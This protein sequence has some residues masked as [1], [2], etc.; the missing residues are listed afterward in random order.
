MKK[1]FL[2]ASFLLL[3]SFVF[4]QNAGADKT[5]KLIQFSGVVV[6]AD[7]LQ[8][9]P[10]TSIYIKKTQHGTIADPS[11]YYS[12]V[13][14]KGDTIVFS[15]VGYLRSY[16]IIPD[17]L[18]TTR[19]SLIQIMRKDTIHLKETVVYPW[20]TREQFKQVF[21]SLNAGDDNLERARKNLSAGQRSKNYYI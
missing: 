4:G 10:F 7:S 5:A 12:L 6:D 3:V 18:T 8:P 2:I 14:G 9:L 20:P 17:T 11:G 21:L 19:Y 1:I 15:E 16:Y 13:A